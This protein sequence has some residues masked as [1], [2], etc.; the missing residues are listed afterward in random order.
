MENFLEYSN[1]LIKYLIEKKNIFFRTGK[2]VSI[3]IVK[4]LNKLGISGLGR[5]RVRSGHIGLGGVGSGAAVNQ[6]F[7]HRV[8]HRT[9]RGDQRLFFVRFGARPG[10]QGLFGA[11]L[12]LVHLL[13]VRILFLAAK[14]RLVLIGKRVRKASL[15]ASS[16]F[17]GVENDGRRRRQFLLAASEQFFDRRLEV[18]EYN[19]VVRWCA[20][21]LAKT[22]LGQ[23]KNFCKN[24]KS[25]DLKITL[26]MKPEAREALRIFVSI[27]GSLSRS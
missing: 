20:I 14:T 10:Q 5:G 23:V 19:G 24:F 6:I 8:G 9:K 16:L 7:L 15:F 1:Y 18:V 17:F 27:T 22:I 4:L 26:R 21:R 13:N 11:R 3:N 25:K 12:V 2:S